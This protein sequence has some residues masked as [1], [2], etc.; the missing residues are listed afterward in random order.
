[1][2]ALARVLS[3]TTITSVGIRQIAGVI[4]KNTIAGKGGVVSENQI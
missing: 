3:D 1:M 2:F 4:L